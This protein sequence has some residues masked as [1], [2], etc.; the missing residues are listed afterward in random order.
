MLGVGIDLRLA[1]RD[2]SSASTTVT[3]TTIT[4]V[5]EVDLVEHG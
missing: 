3:A 4:I 2:L 1:W 5:A